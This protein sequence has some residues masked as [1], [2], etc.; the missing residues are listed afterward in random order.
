MNRSSVPENLFSTVE[1]N[2]IPDIVYRQLVSLI[3]NG[4]LKPGAKLPS[5]RALAL[6]LGVSRQSIRE[7]FYRA[8]TAGL[9]DLKQGRGAFVISSLQENLKPPLSIMLE[10]QAE[11]IF[12]FLEMRK[13]IEG[14]CA[15]RASE[16]ARAADLTEMR[17]T[18]KTMEKAR[19]SDSMWEEADL[20]F[21]SS[22]A[23]ATHNLIAIHVM[24]GLKDSFHSYFRAKKFTTRPERRD[25]LL[26]QHRGVFEAIRGKD[27]GLARAKM[28]E[29]LDY[30][31]KMIGEDLLGGG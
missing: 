6:E 1:R 20:S 14:W 2:K 8:Q 18:L 7:A 17:R 12:E 21:H 3:T 24:E 31:E 19:I 27:P 28:L 13:V 25:L 4:R 29:H 15:E 10:E 30:I 5:E 23:A 9:I 26:E 11:K 16:T 22:V